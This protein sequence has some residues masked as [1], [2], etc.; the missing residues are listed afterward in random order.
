MTGGEPE[1]GGPLVDG[2]ILPDE[3][4]TEDLHIDYTE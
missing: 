4:E 2:P 3:I 1:F